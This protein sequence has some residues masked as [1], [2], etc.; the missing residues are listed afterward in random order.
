MFFVVLVVL[1]GLL[2]LVLQFGVILVPLP[3]EDFPEVFCL[4]LSP[5][6]GLLRLPL[7]SQQLFDL[8]V[9]GAVCVLSNASGNFHGVRHSR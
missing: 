2:N 8:H 9:L 4:H 3:H 1:S 6:C 5:G 7:S